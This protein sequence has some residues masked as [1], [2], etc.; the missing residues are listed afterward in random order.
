LHVWFG[1]VETTVAKHVGQIPVR[2]VLNIFAYYVAFE[3]FHKTDKQRRDLMKQSG[4][5][6]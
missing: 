2:Y 3:H 4:K 6:K 5:T 1:N